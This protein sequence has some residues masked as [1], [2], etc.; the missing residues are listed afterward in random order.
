MRLNDFFNQALEYR[1]IDKAAQEAAEAK[2]DEE[3]AGPWFTSRIKTPKATRG[4]L[5]S[6]VRRWAG[7]ALAGTR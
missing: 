3:K 2:M 7:A 1:D 6:A 4:A 5:R